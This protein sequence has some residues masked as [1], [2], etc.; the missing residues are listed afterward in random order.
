MYNVGKHSVSKPFK[1]FET[2]LSRY[3]YVF[4]RSA[5]CV[6]I[7][8]REISQPLSTAVSFLLQKGV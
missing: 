1:W 5:V 3:H 6:V 7:V 8:S 4:F 2:L